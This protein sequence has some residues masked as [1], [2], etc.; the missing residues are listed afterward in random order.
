MCLLSM[1]QSYF[2]FFFFLLNFK[3]NIPYCIVNIYFLEE[4]VLCYYYGKDFGAPKI[5]TTKDFVV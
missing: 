2:S 4:G 3:L 5:L 1:Y